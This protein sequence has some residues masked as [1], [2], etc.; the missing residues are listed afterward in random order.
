LEACTEGYTE[1]VVM[2]LQAGASPNSTIESGWSCL[3][4]ACR[5]GHSDLVCI[6]IYAYA[7]IS[8]Y[9]KGSSLLHLAML[10]GSL[11]T[12]EMLFRFGVDPFTKDARGRTP[13]EL[14]GDGN[15]LAIYIPEIEKYV[16]DYTM[17]MLM[18]NTQALSI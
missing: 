1:I 12:V 14:V 3:H 15:E 11:E 9:Y 2:L 8:Q 13:I 6:L 16:D 7:D 18:F 17:N 10:S 4:A 5:H